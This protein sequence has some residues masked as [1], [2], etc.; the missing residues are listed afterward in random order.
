MVVLQYSSSS[1]GWCGDGLWEDSGDHKVSITVLPA[2]SAPDYA[3]T[4]IVVIENSNSEWSGRGPI[5]GKNIEVAFNNGIT[6]SADLRDDGAA[7]HWSNGVKWKRSGPQTPAPLKEK[8]VSVEKPQTVQSFNL[9]QE[10]QLLHSFVDRFL[11]ILLLLGVTAV[12]WYLVPAVVAP[13]VFGSYAGIA[14]GGGVACSFDVLD[15]NGVLM[16]LVNTIVIAPYNTACFVLYYPLWPVLAVL[17]QIVQYAT[18]PVMTFG[19]VRTS[20]LQS[21]FIGW[22]RILPIAYNNIVSSDPKFKH[23]DNIDDATQ[24]QAAEAMRNA[25]FIKLLAK[26]AKANIPVGVMNSFV[27]RLVFFMVMMPTAGWWLVGQC[28]VPLLPVRPKEKHADK[29]DKAEQ[30]EKGE[31]GPKPLPS[32]PFYMP[33]CRLLKVARKEWGEDTGKQKCLNE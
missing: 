29:A 8:A 1:I 20:F 22:L 27:F 28:F 25:P 21:T 7:L 24:E 26:F 2:G 19:K 16:L 18:I 31:Q 30:E 6:L 10:V 17:Y 32:V 4:D 3:S 13:L 15:I 33:Q 11:L 14:V 23:F 12:H 5:H 9:Q